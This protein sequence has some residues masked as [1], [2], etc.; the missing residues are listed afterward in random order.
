MITHDQVRFWFDYNEKT[1][2]LRWLKTRDG[3][4][5]AGSRAG[6]TVGFGYLAVS[7]G[8]ERYLVHRLIWLWMT[9][10]WPPIGMMIDHKNGRRDDNRWENLRL[11]TPAQNSQNCKRNERNMTG[12]KG[13]S[14]LEQKRM[15][16]ANIQANGKKYSLG[17]YHTPEEAHA[18]YC[19]AAVTLH[20]EFARFR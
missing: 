7:M 4:H 2:H 18:A 19:D 3:R 14:F 1:G 9:G 15:W 17:I 16:S 8:E 6:I 13:V 12:F 20:G 11:A 5:R 10:D